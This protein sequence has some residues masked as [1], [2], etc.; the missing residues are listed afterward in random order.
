[1]VEYTLGYDRSKEAAY[2]REL[3]KLSPTDS[4]SNFSRRILSSRGRSFARRSVL[5]VVT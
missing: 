2:I 5:L 4:Y 3:R 1:M